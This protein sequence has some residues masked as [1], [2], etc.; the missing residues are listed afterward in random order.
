MVRKKL[1]HIEHGKRRYAATRTQF[2]VRGSELNTP[3]KLDLT[4]STPMMPP[5]SWYRRVEVPFSWAG[6]KNHIFANTTQGHVFMRAESRG[7]RAN[8]TE[9]IAAQMGN[10]PLVQNKLWIDIYAQK[11]SAKG[12]AV[13]FV[14]MVCDAAKDGI[15]LDDRWFCIRSVDW[16]IVKDEP[17]LFVGFGQEACESV[18]ACSSCGRLL[19]FDSF[20]RNRARANGVGLNCRECQAIKTYS[21]KSARSRAKLASDLGTGVFG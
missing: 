11:P 5:M 19:P 14:D 10:V 3:T 13:N 18:Q 12:D 6:S 2:G 16:Q 7:M 4:S 8:L 20:Q 9:C 1:H 17:K 21:A 15:L